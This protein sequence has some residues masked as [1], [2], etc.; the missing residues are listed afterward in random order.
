ML[1]PCSIVLRDFAKTNK[2][3]AHMHAM[4]KEDGD[5]EVSSPLASVTHF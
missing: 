4:M 2:F 5:N 3:E 1:V